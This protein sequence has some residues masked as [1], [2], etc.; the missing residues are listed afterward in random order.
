MRW[1]VKRSEGSAWAGPGLGVAV[2][3]KPYGP[4]L[5][6]ACCLCT[7][8]RMRVGATRTTPHAWVRA[9]TRT[10]THTH[11]V[12]QQVKSIEDFTMDDL[13]IVGYDPHKAIKME[14]AV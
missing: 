6:S 13:E 11:Q 7:N 4:L 2:H 8:S 9:S 5:A 3:C 14:M 12:W 1:F 10:H